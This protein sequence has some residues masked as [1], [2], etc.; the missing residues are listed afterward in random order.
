MLNGAVA[1]ESRHRT[2]SARAGTQPVTATM[3]RTSQRQRRS[4]PAIRRGLCLLV[5]PDITL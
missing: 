5:L 2:G 4:H 1:G 3:W